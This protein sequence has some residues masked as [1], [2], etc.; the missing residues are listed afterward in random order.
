MNE[1]KVKDL[2]ETSLE[3]I[4]GLANADTIVGEPI[5]SGEITIIPV[6]KVSY[7]FGAGGSDLPTKTDKTF[8]GGGSG[9]GITISP[10]AFIVINKSDVRLMQLTEA[11]GAA[12]AVTAIPELIMKLK[13][14]FKKD[15]KK[16]SDDEIFD[17][18]A[19]D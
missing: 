15:K 1:T 13:D 5:K 2:I 14:M 17:D 19:E 3:K 16:T 4:K 18:S 8:F 6:S 12:G 11:S 7:G 10:L 9:A